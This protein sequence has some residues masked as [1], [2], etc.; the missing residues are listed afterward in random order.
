MNKLVL[1]LA[2]G[3]AALTGGPAWSADQADQIIRGQYQAV[4]GDCAGCHTRAEGKPLAGGL[5]LE[6]PF[7]ALVPPNITPDRETGI[8]SWSEA[9][10][11]S[12][13]KSGIGHNGVRLYPAMPYPA[14][15]RMND[16]DI[17][18]LWAYLTTV[19]PVSNK[20]EANQL[21][22]PL[23]IRLAMLGWNALNFTEA[24][25]QPDPSKP[26]EWNRGAY[27][28]Q[29]AGHCGTCHSPK[30]FL[31]ADKDSEFLQGAS[32]QGWFAPDI[33]NNAQSGLGKWSEEDLV[34]YLKTGVNAHSIASGPMAE[35][36]ENSTSKMTD[37]DLKAVAVYLKSLGSDVDS[38][39]PA[40]PDATRM[41]AGEA[42]YRDNCSACHGGDGAGSGALFPSLAGN[43]IVAQGSSETLAR[44][45]LAGSQAVHTADAPT[46]PAMPS[47]AWRLKDQE[48]A[49]VL[50]YV[51]ASWGNAAPAVSSGDV[52]AV[53]KELTQ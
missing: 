31:G 9:D 2:I 34:K 29:G 13:M 32:L 16:R 40:K 10:F 5:P 38:A 47:L 15:T 12:M 18:D 1:T 22:F 44:L 48:V 26:A 46:T 17:S 19:Q 8:G 20:V 52:A 23:N 33:T 41:T 50:T 49:D 25:F 30:S 4:L 43:S 6:T 3:A 21:P 7:G 36:I 35:A 11:R 28:V 53:R 51:R 27:I 42:I 14:Y 39:Q 37:P 45:V 24:S